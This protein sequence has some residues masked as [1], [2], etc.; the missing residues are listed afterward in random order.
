MFDRRAVQIAEKSTAPLTCALV[1]LVVAFS[2]PARSQNDRTTEVRI[3]LIDGRNGRPIS[4]RELTVYEISAPAGHK[5]LYRDVTTGMDGYATI[6]VPVDFKSSIGVGT[7]GEPSYQE[8]VRWDGEGQEFSVEAIRSTGAV[9]K[10][11]CKRKINQ[12]PVPGVLILYLRPETWCHRMGDFSPCF[13][14]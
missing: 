8:C 6:L 12:S 1:L 5:P 13:W 10:N 9:S 7:V 11:T 2:V 3:R 14:E 4:N